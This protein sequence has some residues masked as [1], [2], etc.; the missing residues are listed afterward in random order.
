ME[1]VDASTI[2]TYYYKLAHARHIDCYFYAPADVQ[3]TTE[4]SL[5]ELEL[6]TRYSSPKLLF[7]YYKKFLYKFKFSYDSGLAEPPASSTS[8]ST[9]IPPEDDSILIDNDD[10]ALARNPALKL[11]GKRRVTAQ[12]LAMPQRASSIPVS[13]TYNPCDSLQYASLCLY[14]AV[15]KML[16]YNLSMS[17]SVKIFGSYTVYS[18]TAS[19]D[20]YFINIDPTLLPNGDLLVSLVARRKTSFVLPN[21]DTIPKL[22]D[23]NFAIYLL[24]NP[25]RC[26]LFDPINLNQNFVIRKINR[27]TDELYRLIRLYTGLEK[28]FASTPDQSNE[29]EPKQLEEVLFVKLIPNLKHMNNLTSKISLFIHSIN[30]KK[31]VYW[32]W[33]LC[34]LQFGA[35]EHFM[36]NTS[37]NLMTE[38]DSVLHNPLSLIS[39]FIDFNISQANKVHHHMNSG[40]IWNPNTF[41]PLTNISTG[42]N[43]PEGTQGNTY[44]DLAPMV[45]ELFNAGT[46]FSIKNGTISTD[47]QD[48]RNKKLSISTEVSKVSHSEGNEYLTGVV[49]DEKIEGQESEQKGVQEDDEME[50]DDLFGGSDYEEDE[51]AKSK[52]SYDDLIPDGSENI[53]HLNEQELVKLEGDLFKEFGQNDT[54]E[55]K[56]NIFRDI[57]SDIGQRDNDIIDAA[58]NKSENKKL[59]MDNTLKILTPKFEQG[60]NTVSALGTPTVCSGQSKPTYIDIP[61]DQMTIKKSQTPIYDDPG[62]PLPIMPTPMLNTFGATYG[63]TSGPGSTASFSA[64]YVPNDVKIASSNK[65]QGTQ[66]P[67]KPPTSGSDDG[68]K[69][70]FSPILFNPIIENNIDTK[71]GKG[72]K[73]YVRKDSTPLV[74][75]K[76]IRATSVSG[77]EIPLREDRSLKAAILNGAYLQEAIEGDSDNDENSY[78]VYEEEMSSDEDEDNLF[79]DSSTGNGASNVFQG[80]N[81]LSKSPPLILNTESEHLL[82]SFSSP[83]GGFSRSRRGSMSMSNHNIYQETQS[84]L[85]PNGSRQFPD[86]QLVKDSSSVG[87]GNSF[88]GISPM[89]YD[90]TI[91][92]TGHSNSNVNGSPGSTL[93]TSGMQFSTFSPEKREIGGTISNSEDES[94]PETSNYLPLLLRSINVSTIPEF[95][96]TNNLSQSKETKII[97]DFSM[98]EED[99]NI[100][101][102][103]FGDFRENEMVVSD[104]L[105]LDILLDYLT[106]NII[107]DY[108]LNEPFTN[109]KLI[110]EG[111]DLRVSEVDMECPPASFESAFF[112]VFP[113]CYKVNLIEFINNWSDFGSNEYVTPKDSDINGGVSEE[114]DF[115]NDLGDEVDPKSQFKKL[116]EIEYDTINIDT[117][118]KDKFDKYKAI[119]NGLVKGNH[120]Q[121]DQNSCFKLPV[122]EARVRKFSDIINF[123]YLGINFWRMLSLSPLNEPKNFQLLLISEQHLPSL[124]ENHGLSGVSSLSTTNSIFDYN[125]QFMNNLIQNYSECNLGNISKLNVRRT[126]EDNGM[127]LVK[128]DRTHTFNESYKEIHKQLEL[129]VEQIK[130][131]LINKTNKFEFN[132]PLLLLFVDFNQK[133]NSI[134]QISKIFKNFKLALDKHQLP[135]VQFFVKIIPA[136]FIVKRKHNEYCLKMVSNYSLSKFSMMLYNMCPDPN[137]GSPTAF[138]VR[139]LYTNIVQEPPR[140]IQFKFLGNSANNL[141]SSVNNNDD[142]FLH[143]AYERSIDKNWVSAAWL[144]PLGIVTHTKSWYCPID[145]KMDNGNTQNHLHNHFHANV[146][147]IGQ[148]SEEIWRISNDLFKI[149]NNEIIKK[150]NV[151]GGKKFLVLTRI[152]SIIP[153]DELIHWKKLSVN[154]KDISLIVLSV[155]RA[156]KLVFEREITPAI[157]GIDQLLTNT[158]TNS[159]DNKNSFSQTKMSPQQHLFMRS[160]LTSSQAPSPNL[161]QSNAYGSQTG[162]GG[163]SQGSNSGVGTSG[164]LGSPS[165]FSLHSPQQFANMPLNFLSPLEKDIGSGNGNSSAAGGSIGGLGTSDGSTQ[166]NI[167]RP[168]ST[169]STIGI[170]NNSNYS[171]SSSTAAGLSNTTSSLS[172]LI[173]GADLVVTHADSE[174]IGIVPKLPFPPLSSPTRLAMMVGYLVKPFDLHRYLVYEVCLFSC[175]AFWSL[176]L[177]MHILLEQYQKLIILNDVLG[178]REFD[179]YYKNTEEKDE[180]VVDG[181][182]ET[183][184]R[185]TNFKARGLVPWHIT[186]VGKT[187]DYLVHVLVEE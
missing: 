166:A 37:G 54:S 158:G 50:I 124:F 108:G 93:Q 74:E 11:V 62:A 94:K 22:I 127:L 117:R 42:G 146:Y 155:N 85:R 19:G 119:V 90:T 110:N 24:P 154:H 161:G 180:N 21:K 137:R 10:D 128:R 15:K 151:I 35:Y 181:I 83:M 59:S 156:P 26:H 49:T 31:F 152:N 82:D 68:I 6:E 18:D 72:G 77:H 8:A 163:G 131:D 36:P 78:D 51:E 92:V 101:I 91:A 103:E 7:T 57:K 126:E 71:Y 153:D 63:G 30:N 109:M 111:N 139:K 170:N 69:S 98:M 73:F 23:L 95:F 171:Q 34:L 177:L 116:N 143:L 113:Y 86:D 56:S 87:T 16:Q 176:P 80:T 144:D 3:T 9:S 81:K 65:S 129:I 162:N 55:L 184:P 172:G 123:D 75:K 134:L 100:A 133:C 48:N 187:L 130:L 120:F 25:I 43:N 70:A 142:I 136:D 38:D 165:A 29:D 122:V 138:Q 53:K 89:S 5:L 84:P 39:E 186:A 175:S 106:Q 27:K 67:V 179:G 178:L 20:L 41:Q 164:F 1:G 132:R 44:D 60:S 12:A 45:G 28:P 160:Y 46:D 140:K 47:D 159:G 2:K 150:T 183:Y 32:P 167:G 182:D 107:F 118:N 61:R 173:D 17:K 141:K 135:L 96:M 13:G 148:I 97:E 99:E 104:A 112:E 88:P 125:S 147:E 114:L 40:N 145:R 168:G 149:L 174:F 14:K 105:H 121:I 79:V 76:Y 58:Q 4:Q 157:R 115:L 185:Q 169:P 66:Y 33:E 102:S 64:P 52:K